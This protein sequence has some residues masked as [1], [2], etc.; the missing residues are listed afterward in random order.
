MPQMQS[1]NIGKRWSD[2]IK[3]IQ[4]IK[5]FFFSPTLFL[6]VDKSKSLETHF[7]TD[8]YKCHNFPSVILYHFSK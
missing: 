3:M 4:K 8:F 2:G 7:G 1:E 5:I 6:F